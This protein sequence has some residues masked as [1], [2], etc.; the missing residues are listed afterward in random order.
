M[1]PPTQSNPRIF[2]S[3]SH[4]S[5]EHARRVLGLAE[6]L[7]VEG[8]DAQIDQYVAGTPPRG[9]PRWMA[10]Q[11]DSAQFVLVV[12][13][14]TYHRRFLGR[15]EPNKGKGAD[16]EGSSITLEL[17]RA[18][19]DTSKFVP[20]L[21]EPQDE[22]FIP[23]PLSG[24]T[25]YLLSS[26]DNYAKLYDFLT[27]QAGVVP[28]KLG[29][30]T[31]R[32][33]ERV[34]PLGFGNADAVGEDGIRY[35]IAELAVYPFP[36][37]REV[38][39]YE[40]LG[41]TRSE[42]TDSYRE[43]GEEAPY[44]SREADERLAAVLKR[45]PFVLIVGPSKAGKSRTAYE[46][47]RKATPLVP[48][49]IPR[50]AGDLEVLVGKL[51]ILPNRPIGG[52]L[53]LDD[54]ERFL[55]KGT[56][57]LSVLETAVCELRLRVVATMR[58][59]EFIRWKELNDRVGRDVQRILE[60]AEVVKLDDQ[61]T[62]WEW[63][64]ARALYPNLKLGPGLGESFI[65]GRE[66]RQ[67]YDHGDST[68]VAVVRAAHDWR[69]AGLTGPIQKGTL[70]QLFKG[71]FERLEPT[72]DGNEVV[73]ERGLEKSRQPV[74]RYSAL[75]YRDQSEVNGPAFFIGD[76]VSDFLEQRDH[77][78]SMLEEAWRLALEYVEAGPDY[79]ALG[80]AAY[81]R[82]RWDVVEVVGRRGAGLDSAACAVLLGVALQKQG[83]LEEAK[84]ALHEAI[85]L[86]PR[87]VAAHY[88]LGV[89]LR[90]QGQWQAAEA[91]F[92]QVVRIEPKDAAGHWGVGVALQ[93]QGRSEEAAASF[94]ET[95][96]L[97]P[98]WAAAHHNLG[99]VLH[100][101]GRWQE[102]AVALREAVRLEPQ[103]AEM[104]LH[105]GALL[106]EFGRRKKAQVE[107]LYRASSSLWG[108]EEEVEA[109]FHEAERASRE[110]ETAFR[111]AEAALRKAVRLEPQNAEAH[112]HLGVVLH[113][114][115]RW[116]A[117][118]VA[119]RKAVRLKPQNAEAHLHLGA[120]LNELSHQAEAEA[121]RLWWN[122]LDQ[123]G[124]QQEIK[125]AFHEAEAAFCEAE[126]VLREA[127]RLEPRNASAH[128]H[129]GVLLDERGQSREQYEQDSREAKTA[130]CEAEA[131]FRE[132]VRLEPR[133]VVAHFRLHEL[134][135]EQCRQEE[136]KTVS[137]EA[138]RL[139]TEQDN[140]EM[141][142]KQPV[143]LLIIRSGK[144]RPLIAGQLLDI[145]RVIIHAART[146]CIP[147]QLEEGRNA[148]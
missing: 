78:Y 51:Q 117:G 35:S 143:E 103:N 43:R 12:C 11:L 120:L 6:R 99:V 148:Y 8:V 27:G 19:S 97:E 70:F 128:L 23:R 82:E 106:N 32:A 110:A 30:L 84:D 126:A 41:V 88:Q 131:A 140:I 111:E 102:G 118:A 83:R 53:W 108:K 15:E 76:Y 105:L 56:L 127:V 16:W 73:F 121:Q 123:R 5:P 20:V 42:H 112:L 9:W 58:S 3:Y 69:R 33:R 95:V 113:A 60:R 48:V 28:A 119:L 34:E 1:A 132:A 93:K 59:H 136:A 38:D 122:A 144:T 104:H 29:S 66:L 4:D 2:I 37:A 77:D 146:G 25:H 18:R 96:R 114:Q 72:Q 49:V 138:I 98:G 109:A 24:H 87:S 141:L 17:Y 46:L 81:Q 125:A 71:H 94:H 10:D 90:E 36:T 68:L 52:V 7:R 22:P 101:Q 107:Y 91:A 92:R 75:L 55:G 100:A 64:R 62:D 137:R 61:L 79:L 26:E 21:F 135:V 44:V 74:A 67:R 130:F 133:N 54:L 147:G 50:G 85:R 129:L 142:R 80:L 134:L 65:A 13:T 145:D 139:L 57:S 31:P 115:G 40:L 47:V 39:C 45:T 89:I 116:Q 63:L 124:Q 86:E 14:E